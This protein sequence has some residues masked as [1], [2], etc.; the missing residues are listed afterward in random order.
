MRK[1]EFKNFISS[2]IKGL[3]IEKQILLLDKISNVWI[4]EIKNNIQK[5]YKL[6]NKCNKYI[7]KNEFK[8][9]SKTIKFIEPTYTDCGYGD[10][11]RYG[12]NEYYIEQSVCPNCK[13]EEEISRIYLRNLWE[14]RRNE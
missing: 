13:K 1:I 4:P 5:N 10:D 12:E 6:C 14:K 3:T 8:K 7:L 9:E 2:N 11:D